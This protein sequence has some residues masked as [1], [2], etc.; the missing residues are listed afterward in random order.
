MDYKELFRERK[1]KHI[2]SMNQIASTGILFV[3]QFDF[4]QNSFDRL[5]Y[6]KQLERDIRRALKEG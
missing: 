3:M 4:I 5:T 1:I 2:D 6:K